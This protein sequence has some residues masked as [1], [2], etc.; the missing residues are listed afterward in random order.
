M[1]SNG[2]ALL[3]I[4]GGAHATR[5]QHRAGISCCTVDFDDS[6][7]AP[8]IQ[9]LWMLL[10]GDRQEQSAQMTQLV[11][12]YSEFHHFN[13]RELA[14]IEVFRTLRIM[15]HSAWIARRWYDPAF[16]H[17]FSWFG[18]TRYWSEHILVLREQF[19]ALDE[20]QLTLIL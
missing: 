14:L 10:S 20:P 17:A 8:A 15:H 16:P 5:S 4:W 7:L 19:A 3:S 1:D 9:D 13:V 12:G 6:R 2:R 11:K 18:S